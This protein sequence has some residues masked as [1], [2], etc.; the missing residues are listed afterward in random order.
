MLIAAE[1]LYALVAGLCG[2]VFIYLK[3][4]YAPKL[5]PEP[6]RP[7]AHFD[8]HGCLWNRANP[9]MT[10]TTRMRAFPTADNTY[11]IMTAAIAKSG[12]RLTAGKRR[13]RKRHWVEF[14]G[15]LVEK[16][17]LEDTYDFMTMRAFGEAMHQ[18]GCGLVAMASL[19][20]NDCIV[21]YAETAREWMLAA[22]GAF[23]QGVTVVTVYATLGEEGFLHGAMQ[24]RAKLVVADAK[25]LNILSSV[26]ATSAARYVSR[27]SPLALIALLSPL[28]RLSLSSLSL[29]P[30]SLLS[31]SL[32]PCSRLALTL[33]SS[34]SHALVSPSPRRVPSSPVPSSRHMQPQGP[35]VGRL[36]P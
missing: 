33:L 9:S 23:T 36:H 35:A 31:L 29:S 17:E 25:L 15:R 2:V 22:Q 32:S 18:I 19:K 11:A 7:W 34:S 14:Q 3:L 27:A 5:K 8:E 1:V 30:L 20:R 10:P 4:F 13:I 6:A 28:S 16:L 24:T 12:D 26:F 21:I